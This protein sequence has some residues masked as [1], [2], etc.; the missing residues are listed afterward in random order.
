MAQ[1]LPLQ[2]VIIVI[3]IKRGRV[4][5]PNI[6]KKN[7]LYIHTRT[8]NEFFLFILGVLT[9]PPMSLLGFQPV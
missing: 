4:K 3:I 2:V 1:T 6:N 9:R 7:S 8:Y 5:T